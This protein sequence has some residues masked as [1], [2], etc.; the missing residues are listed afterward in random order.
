MIKRLP[1]AIISVLL[2][3]GYHHPALAAAQAQLDRT[4]ISQDESVW[5]LI[6]VA[7]DQRLDTPDISQI[8]PDFEILDSRRSNPE[9]V[10]QQH[11]M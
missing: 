4:T 1:L 7:T 6:E 2:L 3:G 11:R 5:L 8:T 9:T 10:R